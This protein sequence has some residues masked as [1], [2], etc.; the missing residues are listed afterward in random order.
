VRAVV[1][2][3]LID[4]AAKRHP[5]MNIVY[6]MNFSQQRVLKISAEWSSYDK[7]MSTGMNIMNILYVGNAGACLCYERK[8]GTRFRAKFTC[9]T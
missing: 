6:F 7:Q 2:V 8:T 5:L 3:R 1:E 9:S 4:G